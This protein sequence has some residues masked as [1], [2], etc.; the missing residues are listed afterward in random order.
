VLFLLS[1]LLVGFGLG[2]QMAKMAANHED[3]EGDG[4]IMNPWGEI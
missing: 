2:S 4:P 1:P 3:G